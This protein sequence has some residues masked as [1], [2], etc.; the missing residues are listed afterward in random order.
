MREYR[1]QKIIKSLETIAIIILIISFVA[2][3]YCVYISFTTEKNYA[4]DYTAEPTSVSNKA[5]EKD[6]STLIENINNAV[7]GISKIANK[8]TTIFLQDGASNLGLKGFI[9][10]NDG[11]IVTNQH[12]SGE[13]N[14]TCYVTLENGKNYK[15]SVV[16]SDT[17]LDL[18]IIKINVKNLD[19]LHLGDSDKIKV[20]EQVYAIGNP[21]GFEFQRTVTSG[22]ISGLNRTIKLE[23]DGKTSYMEDLIQTDATINPGNSGGPLINKNGEVLG[24]NSVKITSAEGIGFAVPI[25]IIKPIIEKLA[26]KG[27]YITPT[28]GVFAYDKSMVPYINQ[29]LDQNIKL[30][31]GIYVADVIK[32]SPAEKAGMKRGDIILEIDQIELEKMLDLRKYIYEKEV[33]ERVNIKYIRGNKEYQVNITLAKIKNCQRQADFSQPISG[34]NR[35]R[36]LTEWG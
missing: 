29:E 23:E 28:L 8:G 7:V 5:E 16:W 15:A 18:S 32:N 33:G 13:K 19:Y 24:I 12:V 14:S 17:D 22:I 1:G 30:D 2:L 9:V 10:S 27:G 3:A 25:N 21:I 26:S 34:R 31:K 6:I 35:I 36:F 20:A 11:Y 4:S